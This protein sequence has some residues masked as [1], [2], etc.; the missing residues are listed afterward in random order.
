MRVAIVGNGVVTSTER[1]AKKLREFDRV[2]GVDGGLMWLDQMGIVPDEIIGDLDS[3]DQ[4]LLTKYQNVPIHRFPTDKDESDMELAI[5]RSLKAKE[6]V[7]FGAFGGRIDHS[8]Y[9]L[10]LLRRYPDLLKMDNG[11]EEAFICRSIVRLSCFIGQTISLIPLSDQVAG[12]TT[13]GLKWE[14]SNALF[15]SQFMSLSNVA[16]LSDVEISFSFGEL[17][18]CRGM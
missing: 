6:I 7:L 15:S 2:I 14:L 12:V 18:I 13:K 5:I 1:V 10:A 9:N 8:L 11:M 3:V 4:G 17:L 16:V